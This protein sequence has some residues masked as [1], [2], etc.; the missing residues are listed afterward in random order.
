VQRL[1]AA[2]D[3]DRPGR[4]IAV[5]ATPGDRRVEDIREFGQVAARY[6]DQVIVRE[7]YNLRGR[8]RGEAASLVMQ[9]IESARHPGAQLQ[10]EV[11]LDEMESVKAALDRA[12]RGDLV[13]LCADRPAEVWRYLEGR[14]AEAGAPAS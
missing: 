6:F 4:R 14:R 3:G 10:A 9:G 8:P 12:Q 7:D 1:R 5:V 2:A 13:L 11:I